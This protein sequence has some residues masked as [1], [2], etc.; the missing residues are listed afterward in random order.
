M[1]KAIDETELPMYLSL[2]EFRHKV[3]PI[4]ERTV[5]R[6]ISTGE[7]PQPTARIGRKTAVWKTEELLPWIEQQKQREQSH[8]PVNV[9]ERKRKKSS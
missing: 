7:F 9:A 3:F 8:H 2:K 1:L 5:W 6:M 4:A